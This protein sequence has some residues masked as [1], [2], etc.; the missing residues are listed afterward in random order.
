MCDGLKEDG[1]SRFTLFDIAPELVQR[2]RE[3]HEG[4]G[5]ITCVEG[6]CRA[7]PFADGDFAVVVDKGT[8]DALSSLDDKLGMLRECRRV[9]ASGG[10]ILSISFGSA[11]RIRLYKEHAAAE[12]LE[13]RM[14]VLAEGDPARGHP[15]VFVT[16]LAPIGALDAVPH[17]PSEL[18]GRLLERV[19]RT[20]SLYEDEVEG[21][22]PGLDDL[23]G[24]SL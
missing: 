12:G 15:A 2:L 20:G 3:M 9:R 21:D 16:I 11:R 1:F 17:R 22:E 10:V 14:H 23:L 18:T 6:D 4:D 8:L 24:S 7:M 5:G 13:W 19:G